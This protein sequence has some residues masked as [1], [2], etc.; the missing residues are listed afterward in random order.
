MIDTLKDIHTITI[1]ILYHI[2][3][4]TVHSCRQHLSRCHVQLIPQLGPHRSRSGRHRWSWTRRT[5]ELL[6][7]FEGGMLFI[8]FWADSN[9]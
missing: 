2:I 5:D 4:T 8:T 1:I 6:A 9:G 7:I 3:T